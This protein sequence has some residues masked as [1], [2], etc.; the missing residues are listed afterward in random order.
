MPVAVGIPHPDTPPPTLAIPH[1]MLSSDVAHSR[2]EAACD[3]TG[4]GVLCQR[5]Q[6]GKALIMALYITLCGYI[7]IDATTYSQYFHL[8]VV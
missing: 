4:K 7:I 2:M 8:V 3:W 1:R 6:E 5:D